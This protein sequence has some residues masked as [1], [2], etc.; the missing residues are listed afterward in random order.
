[1]GAGTW[2]AW[3]AAAISLWGAGV[4]LWTRW[5][6]RPEADWHIDRVGFVGTP[7]FANFLIERHDGRPPNWI[8]A[9]LN[10]GDGAAYGVTVEGVG[11]SAE[12]INIDRADV[13]GFSTHKVLGRVATD[14]TFNVWVW[15]DTPVEVPVAGFVI[16]WTEGP[17]RHRRT[18][19]Y[20]FGLAGEPLGRIPPEP[21]AA[22]R[23]LHQVAHRS[24]RFAQWMNRRARRRR[25]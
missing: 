23:A 9:P 11:G 4:V 12:I 1:M 5:R 20:R 3:V 18:R 19:V 24:R 13:R 14:E 15:I 16:R 17:T 21:R 22:R 25:Q 8:V 6:D 7:E 10:I 2:A